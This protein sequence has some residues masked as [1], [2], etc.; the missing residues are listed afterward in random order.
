[1]TLKSIKRVKS[2]PA[3]V[4]LERFSAVGKGYVAIL[5][6]GAEKP[7]FRVLRPTSERGA[8]SWPGLGRGR[9][10]FRFLNRSFSQVALSRLMK[11]WRIAGNSRTNK[12]VRQRVTTAPKERFRRFSAVETVETPRRR[13]NAASPFRNENR[14]RAEEGNASSNR[15]INILMTKRRKAPSKDRTNGGVRRVADKTRP[16]VC[17]GVRTRRR[18]S[19]RRR[20]RNKRNNRRNV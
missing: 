19:K 15:R 9:G 12:I 6:V 5:T 11:F 14:A 20:R 13:P 8:P 10:F 1:M 17:G 3:R 7:I 4:E 2:V 16:S 18:R